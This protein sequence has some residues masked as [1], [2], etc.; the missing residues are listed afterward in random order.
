VPWQ[1]DV[2]IL[3]PRPRVNLPS[4]G[5]LLVGDR[6]ELEVS[7]TDRRVQAVATN[8]DAW[9]EPP[10][11]VVGGAAASRHRRLRSAERSILCFV[12]EFAQAAE[13]YVDVE[14]LP[15]RG[16]LD[17]DLDAA[18][19]SAS[20]LEPSR[21]PG[22][23]PVFETLRLGI[24]HRV[25]ERSSDE[26]RAALQ[27]G[28]L[29][30]QALRDARDQVDAD[31]WAARRAAILRTGGTERSKVGWV[32][33][34]F[35]SEDQVRAMS[36]AAQAAY[37][38]RLDAAVRATSVFDLGSRPAEGV[39]VRVA[40]LP[41][42]VSV[43][44]SALE[45]GDGWIRVVPRLAGSSR[46]SG[47]ALTEV[48]RRYQHRHTRHYQVDDMLRVRFGTGEAATLIRAGD[49]PHEQNMRILE[50]F[51][52]EIAMEALFALI[53]GGAI[54]RAV[55]RIG[56][57]ALSTMARGVVAAVHL[58]SRSADGSRRIVAALLD[59][60][61]T[62]VR[63]SR[64][65][66]SAV[67]AITGGAPVRPPRLALPEPVPRPSVP[68]ASRGTRR[69]LPAAPADRSVE[70]P[71]PPPDLSRSAE[72]GTVLPSAGR[73]TARRTTPT[74][75]VGHTPPMRPAGSAS[76]PQHAAAAEVLEELEEDTRSHLDEMLRQPSPLEEGL[77]LDEAERELVDAVE[78]MLEAVRRRH[79]DEIARAQHRLLRQLH[80]HASFFQQA[81]AQHAHEALRVLFQ[82]MGRP[83]EA[84][85]LAR[86]AVHGW[87][88]GLQGMTPRSRAARLVTDIVREGRRRAP[89]PGPAATAPAGSPSAGARSARMDAEGATLDRLAPAQPAPAGPLR[90]VRAPRDYHV[91]V[92]RLVRGRYHVRR[93]V[94]RSEE[95]RDHLEAIDRALQGPRAAEIRQRAARSAPAF[96]RGGRSARG[97]VNNI[98]GL[99]QEAVLEQL[100]WFEA[101]RAAAARRLG[102]VNQRLP[103]AQRFEATIHF[104]TEVTSRGELTDGLFF[105]QS[106]DGR[107][108]LVLDIVEAKSRTNWTDLYTGRRA[109]I[110]RDVVRL[111]RDPVTIRG[112]T[113]RHAAGTLQFLSDHGAAQPWTLSIPRAIENAPNVVARTRRGATR[114]TVSTG[115][116]SAFTV[117]HGALSDEQAI[118]LAGIVLRDLGRRP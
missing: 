85:D 114:P 69:G 74:Q 67:R 28:R 58:L 54:V 47:L 5:V 105:A 102:R 99:L 107:R 44:W 52:E 108:I 8:P 15:Y 78:S 35:R 84:H 111:L 50:F 61:Q 20:A 117:R 113:Y 103:A 10:H 56:A 89:V 112:T 4:P 83:G 49:L 22:P 37:L 106:A 30:S 12:V 31:A 14:G 43:A 62:A 65:R 104:S 57:A 19:D 60:L 64:T 13:I 66:T 18:V 17:P 48:R 75:G 71:L 96:Q 68:A 63:T 116:E 94:E 41:H 90:R 79:D 51:A 118:E 7:H 91:G 81:G 80:R 32:V 46:A 100:P 82:R 38:V 39:Q 42:G 73:R 45:L 9:E 109:Q 55:G 40:G 93:A 72:P 11:F 87:R 33:F 53:P 59:I 26:A 110:R 29:L 115:M 36:D 27:E 70:S 21:V 98:K 97:A 3:G 2:T 25:V 101:T 23:L 92:D 95:L 86:S 34:A 77:H 24:R 6:V 76:T 16:T 1:L 88:E